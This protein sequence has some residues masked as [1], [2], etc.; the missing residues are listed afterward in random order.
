M[1][2]LVELPF[3]ETLW[4]VQITQVPVKTDAGVPTPGHEHIPDKPVRTLATIRE[5]MPDRLRQWA[6]GQLVM[7]HGILQRIPEEH[8]VVAVREK[9]GDPVLDEPITQEIA[10][11]EGEYRMAGHVAIAIVLIDFSTPV[12]VQSASGLVRDPSRVGEESE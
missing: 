3:F 8:G 10:I 6:P 11:I 2:L 12:G 9:G 4:P 5:G 7:R 1:P